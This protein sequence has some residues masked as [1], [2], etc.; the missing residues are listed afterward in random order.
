MRRWLLCRTY[1]VTGTLAPLSDTS[2]KQY[3]LYGPMFYVKSSD[4]LEGC[5][6]TRNLDTSLLLFDEIFLKY[7]TS[8][9]AIGL[10][11]RD[12]M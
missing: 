12:S 8:K 2:V 3:L 10:F 7:Y 5:L 11:S 4:A 6:L 9:I 1:A